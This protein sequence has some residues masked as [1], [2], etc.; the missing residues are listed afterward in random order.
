MGAEDHLL[1]PEVASAVEDTTVEATTAVDM[2]D[3]LLLLEEAIAEDTGVAREVMRR[4]KLVETQPPQ[5][6]S[7]S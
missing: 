5:P 6:V 7:S 1:E 3:T 2:A 4:T